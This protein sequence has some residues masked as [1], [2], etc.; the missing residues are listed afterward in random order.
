M[1]TFIMIYIVIS[2]MVAVEGFHLAIMFYPPNIVSVA[3]IADIDI[4]ATVR[5]AL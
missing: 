4:G 2:M 5:T 3:D 1:C